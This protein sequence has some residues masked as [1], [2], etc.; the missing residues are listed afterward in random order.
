MSRL[1]CTLISA[2]Q[3]ALLIRALLSW[4]PVRGDS[5]VGKIARIAQQITEPVIAPLRKALPFLQTSGLDLTFL[6][7]V[8]GVQILKGKIGCVGG[9]L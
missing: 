8:F 1:F 6:L 2:F 5:V 3:L 4:F 7:V 9:V